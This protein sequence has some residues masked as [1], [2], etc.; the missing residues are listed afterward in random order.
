MNNVKYENKSK[1]CIGDVVL[2]RESNI[3][4]VNW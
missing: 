1:A 4:R 3:P 2:I